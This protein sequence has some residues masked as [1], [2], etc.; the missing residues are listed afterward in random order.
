MRAAPLTAV[1]ASGCAHGLDLRES[2]SPAALDGLAAFLWRSV[3]PGQ[4]RVYS[5]GLAKFEP[6]EMERLPVP[7]PALP[8]EPEDTR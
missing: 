2:L 4:G 8:A 1:I 5:G 3:T 6:G 7:C